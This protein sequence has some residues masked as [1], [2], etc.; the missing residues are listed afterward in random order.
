MA[1][2][3]VKVCGQGSNVHE[4]DAPSGLRY[5]RDKQGIFHMTPSD[6]AAMVKGG[7]FTP[8]MAGSTRKSVGFRCT[9]CGF[10]T[11][12]RVCGRCGGSCE[13]EV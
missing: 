1:L 11:Y 5:T 9:D 13:K 4:V 8:S 3:T 7:G 12:T 10:G 6:A 2:E